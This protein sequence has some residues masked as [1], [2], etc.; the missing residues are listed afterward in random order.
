MTP[1]LLSVSL[2]ALSVFLILILIFIILA[3]A[4]TFITSFSL[5]V[6]LPSPSSSLLLFQ[7]VSA[8][9]FYLHPILYTSCSFLVHYYLSKQA[10]IGV[11]TKSSQRIC[12]ASPFRMM[13]TVKL[14]ICRKRRR[15]PLVQFSIL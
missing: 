1:F 7:S 9:L 13:Q 15:G 2:C 10:K 12:N 8:S 14:C 4:A 11:S 3:V 5:L 6:L